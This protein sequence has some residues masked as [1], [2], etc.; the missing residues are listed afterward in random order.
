MPVWLQQLIRHF[1]ADPGRKWTDRDII[2]FGIE[3]RRVRRWFQQNQ[4]ITF[5]AFLRSRRLT[6]ALAQ[7]SVGRDAT[8]TA[9]DAGFESL[10]GFRDAFQNWFGVT[11]GMANGRESTKNDTGRIVQLNRILSPLGP[12]VAAAD[13]QTLWLLEFADR[14]MLETQ[15]KR[16]SRTLS[17]RFCPGENRVID[18]TA[19]QLQQYFDRQRIQF[20]L[21]IQIPGTPFQQSVW[22]ELLK[23]EYGQTRSYEQIARA[24]GKPEARRAVGRANGDNRLAI[25]IPCHRVIRSDGTLSGYGGGLRRK[26]WLLQHERST[27]GSAD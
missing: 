6:T 21:P 2:D 1:D 10:S 23:I 15:F 25:I 14:K 13:H 16:L 11:P 19:R 22:S 17:A 3:P 4:G 9:L 12:L 5:H 8:Q 7:L 27:A 20:E 24:I 26:E 18:K